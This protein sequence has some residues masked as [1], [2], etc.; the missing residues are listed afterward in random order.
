MSTY[1]LWSIG[2]VLYLMIGFGVSN[3]CCDAEEFDPDEIYSSHKRKLWFANIIFWPFE[4]G[5]AIGNM[6]LYYSGKI[7]TQQ[8]FRNQPAKEITIPT[9]LAKLDEIHKYLKSS[10]SEPKEK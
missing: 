8:W 3:V 2:A 10:D 6:S 4:L 7:A 9:I 5:C 1:V